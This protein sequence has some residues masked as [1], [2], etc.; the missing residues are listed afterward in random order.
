M[1][2]L[3]DLWMLHI[4]VWS[5]NLSSAPYYTATACTSDIF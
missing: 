4:M 3:T 1:H 5:P 2:L